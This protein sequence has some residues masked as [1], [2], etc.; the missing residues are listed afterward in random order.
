MRR[1][2]DLLLQEP[3]LINRG[4]GDIKETSGSL[5]L[6]HVCFKYNQNQ[7]HLL[8]DINLTIH[9]GEKVVIVGP[10]GC[11]KST[12]LKVMMGLLQCTEGSI[13]IDNHSIK[14]FGLKNFREITASVM[15]EDS[16]LTGS[17]IENISFFDEELDLEGVYKAAKLA[18]IH[19]SITQFQMGYETRVGDMG[20]TLS[21]GQKQRILLARALYKKPKILFLDEA[22]SHLDVENETR[23]NHFLKSLAITQIMIAHRQET[24]KMADRVIDL[25]NLAKNRDSEK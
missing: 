6:K 14:D 25:K 20:S 21:G 1:L 15:Q 3:E 12:L 23:I 4:S 8:H 24:I 19:D 7:D 22:T 2:G 5:T 17:I 13:Y 11:G 10:S 16:L 9:A 18:C